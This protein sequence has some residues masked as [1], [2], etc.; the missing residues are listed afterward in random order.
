[1]TR[2]GVL[3]ACGVLLAGTGSGQAQENRSWLLDESGDGVALM[4]GT[5]DS[6]DI[7]IGFSCDPKE[8]NMRIVEAVATEKLVPGNKAKLRLRAGSTTLDLTGDTVANELSGTVTIEVVGAP[9]PRVA[10]LLKAGPTLTI[11]VEGGNAS[12]SLAGVAPHLPAFEKGCF[13]RR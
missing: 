7:L 5:P 4:Y 13:P 12:I 10:A 9:N 2:I 1:M 3:L 6:D 8:R 11:E